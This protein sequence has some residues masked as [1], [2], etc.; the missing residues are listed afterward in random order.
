MYS[1]F[2]LRNKVR[3]PGIWHGADHPRNPENAVGLRL[4]PL[5]TPSHRPGCGSLKLL[6]WRPPDFKAALVLQKQALSVLFLSSRSPSSTLTVGRKDMATEP[7]RPSVEIEAW[8]PKKVPE[9]A[10]IPEVDEPLGGGL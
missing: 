1:L 2:R 6:Q 4:Q 9:E 5:S 10:G 7:V 8:S 3:F